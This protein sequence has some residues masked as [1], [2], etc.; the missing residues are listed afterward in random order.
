MHALSSGERNQS[1]P[2]VTREGCRAA[3]KLAAEMWTAASRLP[4]GDKAT[5]HLEE[6]WENYFNEVETMIVLRPWLRFNIY[7]KI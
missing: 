3:K 2:G 4:G 7:R 1:A 5:S 6:E